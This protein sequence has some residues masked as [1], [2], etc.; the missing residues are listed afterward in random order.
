LMRRR[1][2]TL[3]FSR[4][5]YSYVVSVLAENLKVAPVDT[6]HWMVEGGKQD[7]LYCTTKVRQIITSFLLYR[8]KNF[9][10]GSNVLR[11]RACSFLLN[12]HSSPVMGLPEK[13]LTYYKGQGEEKNAEKGQSDKF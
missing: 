11:R 10:Y 3:D 4:H 6:N 8:N 13:D 1:S 7:L 12:F 9:I 2:A 5:L